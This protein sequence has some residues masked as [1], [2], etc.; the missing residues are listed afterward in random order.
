[1]KDGLNRTAGQNRDTRNVAAVRT[2]ADYE[3]PGIYRDN[4]NFRNYSDNN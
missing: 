2:V 1:M 3:K 4:M